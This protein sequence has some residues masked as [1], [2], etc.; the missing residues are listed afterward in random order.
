MIVCIV[1]IVVVS[2]RPGRKIQLVKG[3]TEKIAD[4]FELSSG[5]GQPGSGVAG[6]PK[7]L[8][9]IEDLGLVRDVAIL[10]CIFYSLLMILS[11]LVR[12]IY[13]CKDQNLIMTGKVGCTFFVIFFTL[14]RDETLISVTTTLQENSSI[15]PVRRLSR[16]IL[17][18]ENC[19]TLPYLL[20]HGSIFVWVSIV[21]YP[22]NIE[23]SSG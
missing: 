5:P 23:F 13:Q 2:G 18:L 1:C 17:Q 4:F 11:A 6:P 15:H 7:A 9:V 22:P 21:F 3:V 20:L 19:L 8:S 10:C 14:E 16:R 12:Y